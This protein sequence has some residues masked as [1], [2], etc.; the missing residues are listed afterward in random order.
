MYLV[1]ALGYYIPDSDTSMK[2]MVLGVFSSRKK[3][4]ERINEVKILMEEEDS[5]FDRYD[6]SFFINE[7]QLDDQNYVEIW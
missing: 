5:F 4:E 6:L 2:N 3:A 1:T 7:I